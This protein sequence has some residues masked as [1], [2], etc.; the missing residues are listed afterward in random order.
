M[1]IKVLIVDSSDVV[2][3]GLRGFLA[4]A[5]CIDVIGETED[6]VEAQTMIVE[7]RP[8]VVILDLGAADSNRLELIASFREDAPKSR[9]LIFTSKDCVD[10]VRQLL[11]AGV[12]GYL[13]KESS[14]S[15]IVAA[16]ETI[17]AGRKIVSITKFDDF[18]PAAETREEIRRTDPPRQLSQNRMG[19]DLS[20][21]EQEVLA[22]IARGKTNQQIADDLF[23][24]VKTIETYRSRLTRKIGARSRAELFEFANSTGLLQ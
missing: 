20:E 15:E 23:L 4:S 1:P 2:R 5:D 3:A 16:V 21:R 8:D 11:T 19:Q 17:A 18:F 7:Q 10:S 9:L 22:R 14:G 13:T 24:S 12:D 6:C